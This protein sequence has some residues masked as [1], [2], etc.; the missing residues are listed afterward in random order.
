MPFLYLIYIVYALFFKIAI[1]FLKKYSHNRR[2]FSDNIHTIP[3]G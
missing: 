3:S 2:V 1:L